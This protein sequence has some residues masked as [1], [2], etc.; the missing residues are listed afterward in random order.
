MVRQRVRD[1]LCDTQTGDEHAAALAPS[2]SAA[3]VIGVWDVLTH[4]SIV[5]GAPSFP[6]R[7]ERVEAPQRSP[8][9]PGWR[10]TTGWRL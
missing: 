3:F 4:E 7:H 9:A 1:S 6:K 10:I 8:Q 5:I 2:G